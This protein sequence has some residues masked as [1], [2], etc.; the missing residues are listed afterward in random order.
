MKRENVMREE[1]NF[2]EPG[3]GGLSVSERC[4]FYSADYADYRR[5][6]SSVFHFA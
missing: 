3:K 5:F 6:N 4:L 1:K 2:G